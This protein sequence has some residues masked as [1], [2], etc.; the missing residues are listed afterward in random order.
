MTLQTQRLT[1]EEYLKGPEIKARY[2]IVDGVM[3]MAPSPTL[4]HQKILRQLFLSL[5]QF[6][7]ERELGEVL[8]APLDVLVQQEPLRTRQPDLLFVSSERAEILGQIVEG[9]PDL[10]AEVLSPGNSRADI[11]AKLADYA[12]LGIRECWLAS[13]EARSVEVLGLREWSWARIGMWGIGDQVQSE[14]LA[15]LTLPVEDLFR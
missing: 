10:V 8:F 12:E 6:V 5:H 15:G 2:D 4:E 13:P 3:V 1:Y 9:A 11:E 14:V 7:A